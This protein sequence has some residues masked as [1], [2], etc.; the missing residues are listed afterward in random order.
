[1]KVIEQ[2]KIVRKIVINLRDL[3]LKRYKNVK[4]FLEVDISPK[5]FCKDTYI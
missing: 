1:M 3:Y 5:L 2:I 4:F